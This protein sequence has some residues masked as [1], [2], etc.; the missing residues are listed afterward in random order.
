MDDE[1]NLPYIPELYKCPSVGGTVPRAQS[2]TE[3]VGPRWTAARL[4]AGWAGLSESFA[5]VLA[6]LED[7]R[8]SL[9][10]PAAPLPPCVV[11]EPCRGNRL[12]H[13]VQEG[14]DGD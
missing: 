3:A 2:F 1:V 9:S 11:P 14:A 4:G 6:F 7:L 12:R 8:V 10:P 13:D 5:H